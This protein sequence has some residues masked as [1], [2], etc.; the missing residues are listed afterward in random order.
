MKEMLRIDLD[1]NK[2]KGLRLIDKISRWKIIK[3][4]RCKKGKKLG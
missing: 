4:V 1:E 3:K 2:N